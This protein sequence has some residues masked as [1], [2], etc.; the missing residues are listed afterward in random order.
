VSAKILVIGLG[1]LTFCSLIWL[2]PVEI[3]FSFWKD[4]RQTE[5]IL[6]VGPSSRLTRFSFGHYYRKW[7]LG[8]LFDPIKKREDLTELP[9]AA[10]A[11]SELTDLAEFRT[12]LM[13]LAEYAKGVF[14][15]LGNKRI[16]RFRRLRWVT[17]VGLFNAMETALAAGVCWGVKG[18]VLAG[19]QQVTG[20]SIPEPE[21]GVN[22][23]Y[24][25]AG[26][27]MELLVIF[28]TRLGEMLI[29]GWRISQLYRVKNTRTKRRLI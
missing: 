5:I 13:D 18:G 23:N 12:K 11:R 4:W 28:E 9:A 25:K 26:W 7:L 2:F 29:D 15:L 14:K 22:P 20:Q 24:Q 1:I 19:L 17:E 8:S 6:E 21:I 3:R 16:K 10:K 27:R